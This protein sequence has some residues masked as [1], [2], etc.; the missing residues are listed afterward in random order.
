MAD[1]K[2][3]RRAYTRPRVGFSGASANDGRCHV[4]SAETAADRRAKAEA[5]AAAG[6]LEQATAAYLE[7]L[8]HAPDDAEL[9]SGFGEVVLR[10]GHRAAAVTLYRR[11][12]ENAPDAPGMAARLA[13]IL[14]EGEDLAE[15][16]T[17]LDQAFQR[18]A[19]AP[20]LH[21]AAA[22]LCSLQGDRAA[23][24][25]HLRQGYGPQAVFAPSH[26]AGPG[27][28]E[29]LVLV[30]GL[31]G[32]TPLDPLLQG[33]G[34]RVTAV[35]PEFLRGAPPP[36]DLVFN[37]IADADLCGE[38]LAAATRLV[39]QLGGPV[40]NPP[41]RVARTGRVQMAE[42]LRG[43]DGV[44]T[45]TM[46]ALDR[47][48]AG[49]LTPSDLA[50]LG[51]TPPFAVRASGLHFG[52]SFEKVDRLADLP[53]A[54]ERMTGEDLLLMSFLE[55]RSPDGLY[56]KYRLFHIGGE[57]F[58]VHLAA[59]TGWKTHY[60]TSA[61]AGHPDLRAE[62]ARFLADWKGVLG[63]TAVAAA[64]AVCAEVGLDYFGLDVAVAATGALVLF[65]A[66]A[67]M[68]LALPPEEAMFHYRRDPTLRAIAAGRALLR[69]R[70]TGS[71]A[72]LRSPHL[73]DCPPGQIAP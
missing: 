46:V 15:A 12:L 30:S 59:S 24:R 10:T 17:V 62:E 40:I 3:L 42:R 26:P 45:A 57:I 47:D 53:A 68:R 55:T 52:R 9:L 41:D 31:H 38:G 34:C 48:A 32:D 36:H 13:E 16:A 20:A 50:A 70:A 25:R 58:P 2:A 23:A 37:A 28:L 5:L 63:P 4:T 35:V 14:I 27:E 72:A 7:A 49:R 8:P 43:L 73:P 64:Q 56:R 29:L 67:A 54:L 19:D 11:A 39:S 1:V 60:A 44:I 21:R 22:S 33:S 66:N 51:I 69:A 71:G 6:L 18:S 61:M 65:E